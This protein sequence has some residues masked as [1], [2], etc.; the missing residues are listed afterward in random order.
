M[1]KL[2][3]NLLI[4]SLGFGPAIFG[5]EEAAPQSSSKRE[6][7]SSVTFRNKK[8]MDVFI[9]QA[10]AGMM[11]DLQDRVRGSAMVAW[12]PTYHFNSV[13]SARWNVGLVYRNFTA[14]DLL[15]VGDISL[16]LIEKPKYNSPLFGEL[17]GGVQYW[18]GNSSRKFYPEVKAGFGYQFGDG[19]SFIKSFQ[20]SYAYPIDNPLKTH[21]LIGVFT[22]G[23]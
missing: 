8:G 9:F 10:G 2:L 13:V 20:L 18:T 22:F 11:L 7:T 15:R 16:T 21:L 14:K 3:I 17:G 19:E 1:R 5:T 4:S 6:V 12:A 23:F